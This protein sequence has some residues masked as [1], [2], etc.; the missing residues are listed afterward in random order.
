MKDANCVFCRII[1]GSIPSVKVYESDN[2]IAFLDINPMEKG[3]VLVV[4]K[5]HWR[6]ISDV[7]VDAPDAVR[8]AEEAMYIV[9]VTAKA[10]GE[11]LADGT[12]ILQANG[13][14]AGQTV[15]HLHFHVIPRYG[16]ETLQPGW[17]S[18]A[19]KYKDDDERD[20]YA[21]RIADG[22]KKIVESEGIFG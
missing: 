8:C 7:P 4:P 19:G 22:I 13:A 6:T 3:H 2:V 14:C 20:S 11:G 21:T 16:G 5:Q 17:E 18:G 10:L 9:R 15:P 1:D 12:N